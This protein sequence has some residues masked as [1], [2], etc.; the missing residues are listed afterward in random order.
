MTICWSDD[1]SECLPG[2][3]YVSNFHIAV[4]YTQGRS[5][6]KQLLPAWKWLFNLFMSKRIDWTKLSFKSLSTFQEKT[7]PAVV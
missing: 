6:E 1:S 5:G 3:D 7:L 4:I 2:Q